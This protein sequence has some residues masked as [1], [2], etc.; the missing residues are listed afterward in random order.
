M[1]ISSTQLMRWMPVAPRFR[2]GS[3]CA[4]RRWR[5]YRQHQGVWPGRG[6]R[7]VRSVAQ[8]RGARL[9]LL[10]H[11]P[12]R[13][14][15]GVAADWSCKRARAARGGLQVGAGSGLPCWPVPLWCW[16][17]LWLFLPM[18]IRACPT[19]CDAIL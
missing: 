3:G 14:H 18:R 6:D 2:A 15:A 12:E 13:G 19:P 9:A 10:H 5:R 8:R 11:E 4:C 17:G 7:S 1:P 16:P